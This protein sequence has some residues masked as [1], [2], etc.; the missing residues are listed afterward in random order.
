MLPP[1]RGGTVTTIAT[2]DAET[3]KR[4]ATRLWIEK[5]RVIYWGRFMK[6]NDMNAIIEVQ[7]ALEGVPGDRLTFTLMRKL[8]GT[9]V[10]GDTAMEGSEEQM[11]PYSDTVTLDQTRNAIRL[12]G[13]LSERR[14]AWSQRDTAKHAVIAA[15]FR[16]ALEGAR[17]AV[18]ARYGDVLER[19]ARGEWVA[20]FSRL[21]AGRERQRAIRKARELKTPGGRLRALRAVG[22]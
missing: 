4:W 20:D 6:E 10:T 19:K 16:A 3:V 13:R 22:T 1:I 9:G 7:R 5:P 17:A 11:V 12:A 14:T 21:L 2:G 8:S 18:R 15:E